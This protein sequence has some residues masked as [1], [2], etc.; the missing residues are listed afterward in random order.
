MGEYE[1]HRVTVDAII[2]DGEGIVLI[3]RK[4][5]PFQ[6]EWALPGGHVDPG[7]TP[8][9]AVVREAYEE[10]DLDV[11]VEEMVGEFAHYIEDD[12]GDH[13]PLVYECSTDDSDPVGGDDAAQAEWFAYDAI[14]EELAFGHERVLKE[15]LAEHWG[16][17]DRDIS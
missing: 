10:T 2:D 5:D 15:Y 9:D 7:E 17:Q 1:G 8:R 12:R 3:E 4:Y 11:E 14:P 16:S 6:G 13:I